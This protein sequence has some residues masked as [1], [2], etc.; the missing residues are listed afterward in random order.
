MAKK[1]FAWDTEEHVGT[2]QESEKAE[3]DIKV[4]TLNGTQYFVA[5]KRVLKK[6]GWSFAKNQTFKQDVFKKLVSLLQEEGHL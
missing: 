3:H 6:D 1:E 2:I 4:C 5:T